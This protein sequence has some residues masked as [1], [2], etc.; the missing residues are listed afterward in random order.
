MTVSPRDR[1]RIPVW[2]RLSYSMRE[3]LI[4][5]V[6]NALTLVALLIILFPLFWVF[7]SALRPSNEI[8]VRQITLLPKTWTLENF[9]NII[10]N[11]PIPKYYW[12]SM[13]IAFSVTVLNTVIATIGGYG[14]A[15]VDI[16][17]KRSFAR[18]ILL[19][20][21]FPPILLAIPIFIFW[22]Q[23]GLVDSFFG[24]ALAEIAIAL[25]F[26]LW[27]MWKF[28]QSVPESLEESAQMAGATRFRA[29]YE[30]ALPIAKPGMVAIA[31][32][33]YAV[34]WNAY[35]LPKILITDSEKFVLT[36]GVEIFLDQFSVQWAEL[37]AAVGLVIIPSFLFVFFLQKYMLE[38]FKVASFD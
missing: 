19:G 15:R 34:S 18:L 27:M 1:E 16:P 38:G 22:R 9:Q 31:I 30:V 12:N 21:M 29:F 2:R 36:I 6:L 32:F 24:L 25:P 28:F 17:Y 8:L 23:I 4:L 5:G 14:L 33:S 37:M 7:S 26:S 13:V 3:R 35:T 10:F 20:Y 11:R